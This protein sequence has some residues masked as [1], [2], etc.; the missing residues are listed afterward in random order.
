MNLLFEIIQFYFEKLKLRSFKHKVRTFIPLSLELKSGW[1]VHKNQLHIKLYIIR[2][3]IS[4]IDPH[5]QDFIDNNNKFFP[6]KKISYVFLRIHV[7][8]G[9]SPPHLSSS[10]RYVTLLLETNSYRTVEG[11]ISISIICGDT[12]FLRIQRFLS[13]SIGSSSPGEKMST[14][15]AVN[16]GPS[17]FV[18]SFIHADIIMHSMKEFVPHQRD[19]CLLSN[20]SFDSSRK[21]DL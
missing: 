7:L 11:S 15:M 19:E 14:I 13:G 5:I 4:Y 21:I 20:V 1:I 18:R 8:H 10:T 6:S 16:I 3:I 2:D 12:N 9:Y 17:S